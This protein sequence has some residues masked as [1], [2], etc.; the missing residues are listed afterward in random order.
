MN[1]L[2]EKLSLLRKHYRYSQGDIAQKLNIPV[3]EYMKWENGN[4]I[5]SIRQLKQLAD[6]YHV[7][8][9]DLAD[10][11]RVL[12]LSDQTQDDS[13]TIPFMNGKDINMTQEMDPADNMMPVDGVLPPYDGDTVQVGNTIPED[14]DAGATRVMDTHSLAEAQAEE[15]R[16]EPYQE[17]SP[18][19]KKSSGHDRNKKKK[20]S[21]LIIGLVCGA[22]VLIGIILL[23]VSGIG[24]GVSPGEDNR[25]AVGDKYTLYID[26][27]GNL[28]KYGTFNATSSFNGAVQVS[29]FDD[30]AV[31]LLK[32]GKAVSSDGNKT[33][34]GW[35]D[36]KYIAAG[37]DHT[38]AVKKDG[39][40]VCTGSQSGCQVSSW[41]D[42]NKVYAGDGFTI[43]LDQNGKVLVSGSKANAVKGQSDVRDI[44]ISDNLILLA[45][46]SGKVSSYLID[47]GEPAATDDWSSVEKVAAGKNL[48]AGLKENGSV[49][50]DYSDEDVDTQVETWKNIHYLA[51]NGSTIVAIDRSGNMYGAGDNTYH[52][53]ENTKDKASPSASPSE[54]ADN[55]LN[56]P[57]G[58][59]VSATTANVVIKWN[60]VKN[61]G[62]YTV[63]ISGVGDLP[64]TSS[65]QAS[66]A[67][68]SLTS[69]TSYT[70]TVT[71]VPKNKNKYKESS[72][73]ITYTYEPKTL[74]LATP[75]N[76]SSRS[77]NGA[78][79][80]SWGNVDHADYYGVSIDG[81]QEIRANTN[82]LS[83]NDL[84]AGT[85]TFSIKAY[86][87]NPTYTES[88]AGSAKLNLQYAD[89]EYTVQFV[90]N[91]NVV[92]TATNVRLTPG[93]DYSAG[94]ISVACGGRAEM[95][96]NHT[97]SSQDS[98]VPDPNNTL[99]T[100]Q[101]DN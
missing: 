29:A 6:L 53:Y 22:V 44:A 96:Q 51:A 78:W 83:I 87:A 61:A 69:G 30:H 86:S 5:C 42:V 97:I 27:S 43:G 91:G 60:S 82:S 71:A 40:V 66:I 95:I 62:S 45:K 77:E 8:L 9:D 99:V 16:E 79:T 57:S 50:I 14:E 39:K 65:N 49:V 26:A 10:N 46:K 92:Y 55:A 85:Y 15:T 74:K 37:K 52:Q 47:D 18:E 36:L 72:A 34:A 98:I 90:N 59:T 58:I 32:S 2:P 75:G 81:D 41:K 80:I 35:D 88:D 7:S 70:I 38:V 1:K 56:K 48:A 67:A 11:A 23:V 12:N 20:Q 68:T 89:K 4:D 84:D 21:A 24:S 25:L 100:V 13:V 93:K 54:D 63:S 31:A 17:E 3:T 94:D 19:K 64:A 33:V 28:K 76:I 101:T 73:S